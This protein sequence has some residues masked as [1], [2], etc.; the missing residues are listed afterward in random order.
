MRFLLTL[1]A[2]SCCFGFVFAQNS[3]VSGTLLNPEKEG[4]AF[5]NVALFHQHDSSLVK[6]GAA[7]AAGVFQLAAVPKGNY[8]LKALYVGFRPLFVSAIA[9]DG[10]APV[11]LGELLFSP[12][13]VALQEATITAS[14][15]M[16]EVKAD[17]TVFNVDGTIN[18]AGADG[19]SLLRKA[20]N[21]NVDNNDNISVLGRSGVLLYVDGKRL[22]LTGQDLVNYLQSIPAEQIDRIEIITNPGARYEAEGNA[23]IIDIRLKRD[24][25]LGA[26]GAVNANF[27]Q[28][29]RH[30]ANISANGNYRN[31]RLNSFASINAADGGGFNKMRFHSLFNFI[32]QY[33][34]NDNF[35]DWQNANFRFGTD[36]FLGKK[37]IIGFLATGA[38]HHND[39]RSRNRI[40][41]AQM[42]APNQI[43]SILVAD[44]TAQ[45]SRDQQ[46]YNL[47]YRY[48]GANDASLNIDLDYGRYRNRTERYQPNRY[49]DNAEEV[50]LTEI[51]NRFN[52]P[53]DI[54]I[55]TLQTDYERNLWGGKFG[56]GIK[57]SR[58]ISDNSFLV[59][60]EI[61]QNVVFNERT[62]N[63]FEYTENVY[64][65]Y[66]NFNKELN[67]KWSFS[68][69]LRA[70]QTDAEGNLRA[71]LPELQEP[72]VL[73]NYLNWFPSAGLA[74]Q[75]SPSNSLNLN[76]GR[77]INRPDYNVLNPFRNQLSQLSYE[78]GNPFLN[79]EIVNNV[80]LGY[81]YGSRYNAKLSY[82]RT[83]NQI[84]RLI[85]PDTADTRASYIS[86]DNL[87]AQTIIALNI[88]APFQISP[89]WNAYFNA[90]AS[91]I[92]NR[93]D[94]SNGSVVDLQ[95]FTYSIY[96]QHTF[97]LP[98]GVKAE[99]SG[100]FSG[101][102][103]WGGVFLYETSWSLDLGLQK[104]FFNNRLNVRLSANDIFYES[105][106]DGYSD[107]AGMWSYGSGR[108]D[109]RRVGI[110]L[111]YQL[112][113]DQ[114]KSRRRTTGLEAEAARAKG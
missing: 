34:S 95:A 18:S 47:N 33:E 82:S 5:A 52:T 53:T 99:V 40:T 106:W 45:S 73:L 43:D 63:R 91:H 22:P 96:Q 36:F 77:R 101:P 51:I 24:K 42:T 54:D 80:E 49:Y 68:A 27:S 38:T 65:A 7:D 78:K 25:S 58:V 13:E 20:P 28:G 37:H 110:S 11:T 94:Y 55:Y 62:S 108:W 72:P 112:G 4:V 1:L 87:A 19:M 14:R 61:Q 64:A 104:K 32:E 107:F 59:Y 12:S 44:N 39:N 69:G 46:T 76:A 81:T 79:P 8:F 100:Y 35:N 17:R 9:V 30:R 90:G 66:A 86:W 10:V 103:I 114:V 26:N 57:L 93:A 109:S 113:N 97:T 29:E 111:G 31:K 105:G 23:G 84:T 70:E 21:V 50:V 6:A 89:K 71:F 74:W 3:T 92:N 98:W 15:V 75:V 60:D 85:A 67:K 2:V 56:T 41:L 88:S 102:G 48:S 83:T 16:V